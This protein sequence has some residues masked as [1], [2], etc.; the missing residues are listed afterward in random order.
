[1][2]PKSGRARRGLRSCRGEAEL[3]A[4]SPRTD[5]RDAWLEPGAHP[6]A[7]GV[8][9]I[10]LPLPGDGLKAVNVYAI[11][12]GDRIALVD[13]GWHQENS[14]DALGSALRSIGAE[15]GDVAHVLVTHIHHDHYGQAPALRHASGAQVVLGEGERRSMHAIIDPTTRPQIE[16]DRRESLAIHGAAALADELQAALLAADAGDSQGFA[17][18]EEPDVYAPDALRIEL[19]SRSIQAIATPGHTRG[20]I[21]FFDEAAGVLFAG[22]HVLPHI[23][24]SIGVEIFADGMGLID[25][26]GSLALVR[27][28][29]ARRV[30]P[31]HGPAFD[32][33]RGR[34]DEL[35]S[36]HAT[37]LE[38]CV[39]AVRDAP[40]N[41]FEVAHVLPW[42]RRERRYEELDLFNKMLAVRETVAHLELLAV[43]GTLTRTTRDGIVVFGAAGATPG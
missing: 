11:E 41:A 25:F 19:R 3:T 42:T 26:I 36:H 12:D 29:P 14:W 7:D 6:V 17:L 20:H 35:L 2:L 9:R 5:E 32:D 1:M 24:P 16:R 22:D 18:W 43:Q 4:V 39:A 23:T 10:P 33:L 34:V 15:V 8:Y 27:Q 38:R 37:R 31:A 13:A 21:S 28:L 40:H 30:L